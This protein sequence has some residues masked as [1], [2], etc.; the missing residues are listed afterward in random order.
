MFTKWYAPSIHQA[1]S[2]K[3]GM[4]TR[5]FTRC[6]QNDAEE[7]ADTQPIRDQCRGGEWGRLQ[8]A[9]HVRNENKR[10]HQLFYFI[11]FILFHLTLFYSFYFT[12]LYFILC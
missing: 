8:T 9:N 11:L 1:L 3:A 6:L 4:F 2:S 12:F 10:K 5:I 7:N